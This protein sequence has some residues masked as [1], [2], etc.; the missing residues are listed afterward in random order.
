MNLTTVKNDVFN[1]QK[2]DK[3]YSCFTQSKTWDVVC[4]MVRVEQGSNSI[5][6][7]PSFYQC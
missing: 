1:Q 3:K 7:N 2:T 5:R 6:D 4:M